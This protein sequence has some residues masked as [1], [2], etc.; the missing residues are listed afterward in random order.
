MAREML[1]T[2]YM[3]KLWATAGVFFLLA[4]VNMVMA[5]VSDPVQVGKS[6]SKVVPDNINWV[7]GRNGA[8]GS[9]AGGNVV[10]VE[11]SGWVYDTNSST[12][13]GVDPQSA[14]PVTTANGQLQYMMAPVNGQDAASQQSIPQEAGGWVQK[15]VGS[16]RGT[17]NT[18]GSVANDRAATTVKST[19][20]Q[21]MDTFQ[22]KSASYQD[23]LT[24]LQSRRDKLA[25]DGA[26]VTQL[27]QLVSSAKTKLNTANQTLQ[28]TQVDLNSAVNGT[29]KATVKNR[30]HQRLTGLRRAYTEVQNSMTEAVYKIRDIS[31][32]GTPVPKIPV[33]N[34]S[35][36]PSGFQW[37]R[38][39]TN[40]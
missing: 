38:S 36:Y 37:L 11:Q 30:I 7:E 33:R 20:K 25:A 31:A 24:K 10:H 13:Q 17:Q 1:F 16:L 29:N 27:D 4:N 14:K 18:S 2:G 23:F 15:I 3:K 39:S 26:N 22:A 21:I 19:E 9:G 8:A 40:R 28:T 34:P 12:R 5:A 6:G 32:G 35:A